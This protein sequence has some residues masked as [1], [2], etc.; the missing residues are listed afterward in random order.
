MHSCWSA[1]RLAVATKLAIEGF[2]SVAHK[3]GQHA[4]LVFENNSEL[5]LEVVI[6]RDE[7]EVVVERGSDGVGDRQAKDAPDGLHS[8]PLHGIEPETHRFHLGLAHQLGS[9][10]SI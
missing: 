10:A 8:D 6:A 3:R 5:L 2:A 7:V 4:P 1:R 9:V